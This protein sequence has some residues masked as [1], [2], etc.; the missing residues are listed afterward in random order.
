MDKTVI[1]LILLFLTVLV[2]YPLMFPGQPVVTPVE[3]PAAIINS[4]ISQTPSQTPQNS[5]EATPVIRQNCTPLPLTK[6][7]KDSELWFTIRVPEDWNATTVW[8]RGYGTWIGYYF[9]TVLGVE[10]PVYNQTGITRRINST[11]L[12]IMTYAITR[13]QDQDY[14]NDFR[15]NWIPTPVES[16]ETINGIVFDRF[17]SKGE[18]TAVGY[19]VKK[20]SANERGY[21]TVIWYYVSPSQC[22]EEI[23]NIIHSFRYLSEREILL[24]NV[25]GAEIS[26]FPPDR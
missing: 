17:E 12:T 5:P 7:L 26:V 20:A 22:Q 18:G 14:R 15:Q 24:G 6:S 25:P 1:A 4:S 23:E 8:E 13:S 2:E 9:Y 11:R 19:V 21:A 10:E 16:T 3:S